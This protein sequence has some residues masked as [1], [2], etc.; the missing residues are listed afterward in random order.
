MSKVHLNIIIVIYNIQLAESN[1][2][3]LCKNLTNKNNITIWL[4]DNSDIPIGDPHIDNI[5]YISMNGNK[6]LSKA[7]NAAIS[8]INH[9][10]ENAIIFLDQDTKINEDYFNIVK[11]ILQDNDNIYLLAPYVYDIKGLLSPCRMMFNHAYR[12]KEKPKESFLN[13]SL[14]NSGLC[15]RADVFERITFNNNLFLDYIDHDFIMKFKK[16]YGY[17]KIALVDISFY[18]EF[19]GS[20]IEP[21]L[22]K[23]KRFNIYKYDYIEYAKNNKLLLVIAV[24]RLIFRALKLGIQYKTNKF[25]LA[26]LEMINERRK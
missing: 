16:Y 7:Y 9:N 10:K 19:S 3:L 4:I 15:V 20:A 11:N 12:I 21:L 18:Q 14:I 2:Y 24:I 6:G 23:I 8:M 26:L 5:N 22:K 25:I 17:K 13:I 1:S